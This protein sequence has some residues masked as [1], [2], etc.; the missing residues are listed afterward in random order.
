MLLILPPLPL[1]T[2]SAAMRSL[3]HRRFVGCCV[4]KRKWGPLLPKA[5]PISPQKQ[6]RR[7][8]WSRVGSWDQRRPA[9]PAPA[10]ALPSGKEWGGLVTRDGIPAPGPPLSHRECAGR[11]STMAGSSGWGMENVRTRCKGRRH[12]ER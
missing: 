7:H 8:L 5:Q 2:R 6:P 3:G 1:K 11:G 9:Q 4:T 10:I 12:R